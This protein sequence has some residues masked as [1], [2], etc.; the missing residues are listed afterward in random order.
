MR[1]WDEDTVAQPD[2]LGLSHDRV[3]RREIAN[4]SVRAAPPVNWNARRRHPPKSISRQ[5][6]LRQGSGIQSVTRNR[7]D[8]AQ[9]RQSVPVNDGSVSIAAGYGNDAA[10]QSPAA[11]V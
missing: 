7:W 1:T 10:G 9:R 8:L 3:V 6:W 11:N 4:G 2:F 5:S